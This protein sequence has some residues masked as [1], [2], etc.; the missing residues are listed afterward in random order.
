MN[1]IF[2]F[3]KIPNFYQIFCEFF[4]LSNLRYFARAQYDNAFDSVLL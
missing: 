4:I 1:Y 3:V 2:K